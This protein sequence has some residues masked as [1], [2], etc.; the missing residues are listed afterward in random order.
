M[1]RYVRSFDQCSGKLEKIGYDNLGIFINGLFCNDTIPEAQT[2]MEPDMVFYQKTPARIIFEMMKKVRI[3]KEDVFFD[4][5][6]GMGQVV[7]LVNLTDVAFMNADSREINYSQGTLFFLYTS[8]K[9][10][11]RDQMTDLLRGLANK[12]AV[13][14]LTYGPCSRHFA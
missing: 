12:K 4:I 6:S 13:R 10:K 1:H 9:G 14:I 7:L 5:G 3:S 2:E 8:S 11:T